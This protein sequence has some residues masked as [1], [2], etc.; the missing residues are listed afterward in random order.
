MDRRFHAWAG[1]VMPSPID[2]AASGNAQVFRSM[3]P[4]RASDA[5][6]TLRSPVL[7]DS[8]FGRAS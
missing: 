1:A 2:T 6:R 3:W 8:A 4:D 7:V 5:R